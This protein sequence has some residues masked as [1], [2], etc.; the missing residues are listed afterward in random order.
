MKTVGFIKEFSEDF[1]ANPLLEYTESE[2]ENSEIEKIIQFLE[3]GITCVPIMGMVEDLDEELMG[4]CMVQ[5]DGVWFWPQYLL[6]FLKKYPRFRLPEEFQKHA[7]K[8]WKKEPKIS[9]AELIKL[10]YDFWEFV[11]SQD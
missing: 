10:E 8:N 4:Y 5:T 6:Q 7:I 3:R 2:I 1:F 9:E 11:E